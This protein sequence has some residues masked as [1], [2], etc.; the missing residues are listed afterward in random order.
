MIGKLRIWSTGYDPDGPPVYDPILEPHLYDPKEVPRSPV[1]H[2]EAASMPQDPAV[3][4][5]LDGAPAGWITKVETFLWSSQPPD[6]VGWCPE[7][8]H[9]VLSL[10]AGPDDTRPPMKLVMRY[11]TQKAYG[12]QIEALVKSFRAVWGLRSF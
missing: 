12:E 2:T 3:A 9:L 4:M 11:K 6:A 10:A 8:V 5:A 7:E 1:P